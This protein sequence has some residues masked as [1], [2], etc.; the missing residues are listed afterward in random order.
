MGVEVNAV[1][2]RVSSADLFNFVE[3]GLDL[4]DAAVLSIFDLKNSTQLGFRPTFDELSI[5]ALRSDLKAG[6]SLETPPSQR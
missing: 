2:G 4:P 6:W 1:A 3:L 5:G